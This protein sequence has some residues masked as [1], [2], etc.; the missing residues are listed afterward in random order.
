MIFLTP[1]QAEILQYL[2]KTG[3]Y[4]R[5]KELALK[6]RVSERSIRNDSVCIRDYCR[7][8]GY[9]FERNSK[10]GIRIVA[11]VDEAD[12]ISGEA[13][14]SREER[15]YT[16]LFELFW[17]PGFVT[18]EQ[19]ASKLEVSKNTAVSDIAGLE[20]MLKRYSFELYRKPNKGIK[21]LGEEHDIRNGFWHVYYEINQ[22]PRKEWYL[23]PLRR[24]GEEY[25][26]RRIL[27]LAES[28]MGI[29]YSDVSREEA[30]ICLAF[31]LKRISL[32]FCIEGGDFQQE[33]PEERIL[34]MLFPDR[35]QIGTPDL[36]YMGKILKS[37]KLLMDIN[38]NDFE[39][40][41]LEYRLFAVTIIQECEN[42][43]KVPLSKDEFLMKGL[44]VH[45]KIA[46]YRLRNQLVI[47]NPLMVDI[48]YR[49]PFIYEMVKKIIIKNQRNYQIV[50]PESEI[51][52]LA[53]YIGAAF[54]K[55]MQGAFVPE[56]IVI[57]GWGTGTSSLL[58]ARLSLQFPEIKIKAVIGKNQ[59]DFYDLEQVDLIIS[60]IPLK[61]KKIKSVIVNPLLDLKDM[62]KI[63]DNIYQISYEKECRY[64]MRR[65]QDKKQEERETLAGFIG[66]D[67]LFF[68]EAAGK[69]W[70]QII[71]KMGKHLEC[72]GCISEQYTEDA[73]A[74]VDEWGPY[75]V[76]IPG[77]AFVH[78]GP[79]HVRIPGAALTV[80]DQEI[81]FGEE[82]NTYVKCIVMFAVEDEGNRLLTDLVSILERGDNV[83][84]LLEAETADDLQMIY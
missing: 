45:L 50:F 53:A 22:S 41:E 17:Q 61:E 74:S 30:E 15:I 19:L 6:F 16:I 59:L 76:F 9:L 3:E 2:T 79:E 26:V 4:A 48:Q 28:S 69:E 64:L 27:C 83:R 29:T 40:V 11:R 25:Q 51:A 5:W 58:K 7:E 68:E 21:L 49:I 32:G 36:F 1:R 57:C 60:T 46:M 56:V 72:R 71:K 33:G 24:I 10:K 47:D 54:E 55:S 39:N 82:G 78:A 35:M 13:V 62:Q 63:K 80:L 81:P 44:A 34:K 65:L 43:L 52:Y 8:K 77:I 67:L 37:G 75:M 12:Q 73:I 18:I 42:E 23:K 20:E 84:K 70:R 38:H 66:Q 14:L 31:C